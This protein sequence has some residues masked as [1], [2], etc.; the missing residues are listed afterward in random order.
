MRVFHKSHAE[1]RAASG[2]DL[3]VRAQRGEEAAFAALFEAYKRRVYGLCL[4]MTGCPHEAEDLTQEVFLR[5]FRKISTFRGESAFSTW[6]HRLALN[7]VVMHLRKKRI[8]EVPLDE[9][10]TSQEEPVK[11]EYSDNDRRLEGC[12]DRISLQ[13]A[14][15]KLPPGYR[16]VVVLHDLQEREHSEIAKILNCSIGTCKSQLH[17]A[18][19]KLRKWLGVRQFKFKYV[20]RSSPTSG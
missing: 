4:R 1:P 3:V 9:V 12:V 18:R 20:P 2:G 13:R 16:T 17:K 5:V 10:D 19:L 6:L 15:A 8:Q 11:R 7:V 14:I